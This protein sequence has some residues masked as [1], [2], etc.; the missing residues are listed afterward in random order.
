MGPAGDL[1]PGARGTGPR[2][3]AGA[4]ESLPGGP[5]LAALGEPLFEKAAAEP[6]A[7]GLGETPV[8][9]SIPLHGARSET[10]DDHD[11]G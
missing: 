5:L 4:L 10:P 1:S 8:L 3:L 2:L 11:S 6:C 7:S 9:S